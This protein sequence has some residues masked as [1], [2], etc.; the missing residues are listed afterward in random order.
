ME[1]EFAQF[2]SQLPIV[3]VLALLLLYFNRQ[4]HK[5]LSDVIARNHEVAQA[6]AA[7]ETN[8]TAIIDAE[9]KR[10]AEQND[11]MLDLYAQH[12]A[13]Q[14]LLAQA[15][16]AMKSVVTSMLDIER[17][18]QTLLERVIDKL[19]TNSTSLA[20]ITGAMDAIVAGVTRME[21]SLSNGNADHQA[22]AKGLVN[23]TTEVR[24]MAAKLPTPPPPT[25][26]A[27]KPAIEVA[28]FKP[29]TKGDDDEAAVDPAA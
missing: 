16:D 2:V 12:N 7:Q 26:P 27:S 24:H 22:I 20:T 4:S 10:G 18:N 15:I 14:Q 19:D 9:R 21:K 5:T 6:Q 17:Q 28:A 29:P 13:T 11:K 3:T 1:L 23:L 8:Q 25:T